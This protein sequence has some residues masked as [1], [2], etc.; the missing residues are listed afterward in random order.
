MTIEE[1]IDLVIEHTKQNSIDQIF[2]WKEIPKEEY[3]YEKILNTHTWHKGHLK[4]ANTYKEIMKS[5]K[6]WWNNMGKIFL[7]LSR[8]A[9]L[10]RSERRIQTRQ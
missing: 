1:E 10:D 8:D 7:D 3:K 4:A 6:W 5:R 2:D 9:R